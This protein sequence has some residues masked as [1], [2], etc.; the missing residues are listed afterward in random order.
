METASKTT[1]ALREMA[2]SVTNRLQNQNSRQTYHTVLTRFLTWYSAAGHAALNA[3][4]VRGYLLYLENSGRSRGTIATT[5]SVLRQ[6]FKDLRR[7]GTI[8]EKTY[9]DL[10]EIR[11]RRPR[12]HRLH[13]WLTLAEVQELL[14]SLSRDRIHGVRDRAILALLAGCGLRRFELCGLRLKQLQE[15]QGRPVIADISG[16]GDRQRTVAVPVW[17]GK[18]L[19]AW[20]AA[21]TELRPA[22]FIFFSIRRNGEPG[23]ARITPQGVRD[24]VAHHSRD[25]LDK[26]VLPHDL[27]RTYAQLAYKA[28]ADLRQVQ[29]SLGHSSI[30][31]TEIYL[32]LDQDFANAPGDLLEISL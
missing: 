18:C 4:A 24:I 9:Q 23:S 15:T 8:N 12:G 17:A 22:D 1:P 21:S 28:G 11:V 3:A 2:L 20:L 31:T 27:R 25:I 5:L 14:R 19:E 26:Q 30:R 6:L 7:L 13:T 10:L 32:G 16:K 29:L